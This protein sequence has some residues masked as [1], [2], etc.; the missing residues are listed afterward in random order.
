MA[1]LL[2]PL[3]GC[4]VFGQRV[5]FFLESKIGNTFLLEMRDVCVL[6]MWATCPG[7]FLRGVIANAWWDTRVPLTGL[8]VSSLAAFLSFHILVF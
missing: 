4:V 7:L 3:I 5:F 2:Q 8:L 1:E 6:E